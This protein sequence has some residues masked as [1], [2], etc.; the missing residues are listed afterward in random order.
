MGMDRDLGGRWG[1]IG[2]DFTETRNKTVLERKVCNSK[3]I[4]IGVEIGG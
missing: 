3:I 4:E 2:W 1:E